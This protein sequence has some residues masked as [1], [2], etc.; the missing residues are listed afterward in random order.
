M[1]FST[2]AARRVLGTGFDD[3]HYD[4]AA[5]FVEVKLDFVIPAYRD[6]K[7]GRYLYSRDSEIFE[8]P[9]CDRIWSE[10]ATKAHAD[11]LTKMG[12][13]PDGGPDVYSMDLSPLHAG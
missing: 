3:C 8:D 12:F 4:I 13:R 5:S 11:Y 2:Q 9:R 7:V 10:A 1:S 6:F